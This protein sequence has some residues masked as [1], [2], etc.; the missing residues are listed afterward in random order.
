VRIAYVT[1]YQGPT[2]VERRQIVANRSMSNKTKIELVAKLLRS[3][4]HSVE[5]FSHGE[6]IENR[7]RFYRA[8]AE[9]E[10]F[11]RDI[12]VN[13]ISSLAVGR[14]N[15]LWASLQMVQ[16][17]KRRHR[18]AP[19]DAII[20]FNLKRPQIA[21]ARY[22]VRRGIP[23]IFEYEDDVFR[24]VEG[25]LSNGVVARY[26][27]RA[28][29]QVMGAVSACIA[30][31]PH[32]LSQIRPDAPKLLL[33]GVVGDDIVNASRRPRS[34]RKNIVLFSGTH[35]KSNGVAELIAAWRM[36]PVRG[37]ELHITGYGEMSDQLRQMAHGSPGIV[38]HG[39][40][41]RDDL[42]SL[43]CSARICINP[44]VVSQTPGNV[45]AFK[46]IEYLAAGA[47]VL[48]TRM[49]MLEPE[50][51]V[52]VTYMVDNGPATIAAALEH[53]VE[54]RGY[55]R[56]VEGVVQ[57]RYGSGAVAGALEDVL[58]EA[59]RRSGGRRNIAVPLLGRMDYGRGK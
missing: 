50:I 31:S 33:R 12:P 34:T 15:G 47:H 7:L 37:W 54:E 30:V 42:V 10:L 14:L 40:L 22:A 46:I 38:F 48:T 39:L 36:K 23:V 43:M 8:F 59:C 44:H 5:V 4:T 3:R 25:E 45:F 27:R 35:I 56:T 57:E 26:H 9:P 55:E 52:G 49:G 13:Y 21:C 19:F 2:L 6:V 28:Y 18:I 51:E 24:S 17:L 32:L 53:V 11:D 16:L 58:V 41:N 20:I 1:P 29:R